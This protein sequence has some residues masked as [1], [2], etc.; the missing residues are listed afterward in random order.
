[1]LSNSWLP[2]PCTRSVRIAAV[3]FALWQAY[4]I[5]QITN[6]LMIDKLVLK[7]SDLTF[8]TATVCRASRRKSIHCMGTVTE[9][10]LTARVRSCTITSKSGHTTAVNC[11]ISPPPLNQLGICL[12]SL[13]SWYAVKHC[14]LILFNQPSFQSFYRAMLRR[15]RLCHDKLT[16]R[17]SVCVAEGAMM[18]Q[19]GI[20]RK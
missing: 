17:P 14:F 11:L 2:V 12:C 3:K 4:R 8:I 13:A 7:T 15:V 5:Y 1:M 18:T 16:V 20:L 9:A 19:V 6:L 10:P